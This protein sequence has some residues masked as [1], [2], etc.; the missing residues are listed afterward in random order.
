MKR[1]KILSAFFLLSLVFMGFSASAQTSME[2]DKINNDWT[3]L[4]VQDGVEIFIKKEKCNV[5]AEKLFTYAFI[6]F[7]NTTSSSKKV[8]FSV[9]MY[10]DSGCIG[11]GDITEHMQY[12]EVPASSSIEGDCSFDKSELSLLVNNPYQLDAG[13]LESV[14]LIQLKI[15]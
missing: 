11:C 10:F 1:N 12:I 8:E 3:L 7:N 13:T 6:K 5:G 4:T 15:K 14:R 2:A 9:E